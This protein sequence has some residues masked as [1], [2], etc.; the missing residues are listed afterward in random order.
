MGVA[1]HNR[2]AG[3]GGVSLGGVS[4]D[5]VAQDPAVHRCL[6]LPRRCVCDQ[7]RHIHPQALLLEKQ[8]SDSADVV[9]LWVWWLSLD[10]REEEQFPHTEL[11]RWFSAPPP[12]CLLRST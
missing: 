2:L 12:G 8:T 7:H 4:L 5:A 3:R 11:H 6:C 10:L 9:R 1:D